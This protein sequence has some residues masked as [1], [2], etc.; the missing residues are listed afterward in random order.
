MQYS[1]VQKTPIRKLQKWFRLEV[2][3]LRLKT[4]EFDRVRVNT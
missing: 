1:C 4:T 3:T 2:T